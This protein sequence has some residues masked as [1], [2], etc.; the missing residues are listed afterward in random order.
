MRKI[1]NF[2]GATWW[3]AV[4]IFFIAGV[5]LYFP[6]FASI[7]M[8]LATFAFL[9]LKPLKK[10]RRKLIPKKGLQVILAIV[11]IIGS[12]ASAPVEDAADSYS[13][14]NITVTDDDVTKSTT[15]NTNTESF[16]ILLD[17][18]EPFT[19]TLPPETESLEVDTQINETEP[20]VS[21]TEVEKNEPPMVETEAEE[22]EPLAAETDAW[23]TETMVIE[24]EDSETES[25]IIETQLPET[26]PLVV[27][28]QLPETEPSDTIPINSTFSI[29]FI[30]VGQSD[31]A[32]V[33]CDGHYM[34]IDGG[35]KGDSSLIYTLLK[36]K[37]IS[38]LD[39]VVGTHAHEDHI[40]GIPGAY[41]YTTADLT[42]C[43]VTAY[44][45]DAFG[46]FLKY[47]NKN[48]GGITV[49]VAGDTYSLGSASIDILGV[50]S[51]DDPNNSS[52]VLMITYGETKFLFAGDAERDA[53]QVILNSGVSLDADVL[54]VGHHGSNDSTTYPFLREIM[55]QYAVISVGE[56][57]SYDHPTDDTLS[58]LRDAD[59]KVFRTDMQ[60]DI[61]CTSDGKT[62]TFSVEKNA[63]VDT[64]TNPVRY[65]EPQTPVIIEPEVTEEA[66]AGTDYILN[67]NTKKFH[68]TYCSSV[69]KMKDKNKGYHTGTRDEVIA[70]GYDPCG[71][72]HP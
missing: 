27:E 3:W 40:G 17:E 49:P 16:D 31:A 10:L 63:D 45:T 55:P 8:L 36:N 52:I 47:A 68:Y 66:E 67:T 23:E 59:V 13:D 56:D 54:K 39:I 43:P 29:H 37:G 32:L 38:K 1:F 69:K 50:N 15:Q 57:N 33:E 9:P 18:T 60:G 5:F 21:K 22:T 25:P 70:M 44:D 2:V 7:L 58:R 41:N 4:S 20:I 72:C 28:T 14:D 6:S 34:L 24:T 12:I 26:L 30:D 42:L 65:V 48:G 61:Y 46:D 64:L 62:V 51:T 11:L 35:N 53:E 71:N 19:V